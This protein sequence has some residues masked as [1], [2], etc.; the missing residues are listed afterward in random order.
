MT[1][2]N[3]RFYAELA[4][5]YHLLF[6]DWNAAI[7]RQAQVL[8][9]LIRSRVNDEPLRLLDCSCGIGTQSLGLAKLGYSVVGSDLCPAAID[10]AE[11]EAANRDLS[12]S[13]RISDMTSLAEIAET[14]FDVV[15]TL[16]NALPHLDA[17]ELILAIRAMASKIKPGGLLL[18]SIRDY[19]ALKPARPAIQAP[20]FTVKAE[21]RGSF[22]R[23]GTGRERTGMWSTF[24]SR[25]T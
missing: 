1:R 11:K 5:Y 10:R 12:I 21:S 22:I 7:G 15:A 8:N 19:D 3:V 9:P 25:S 4:A 20:A 14:D 18:A 2:T 13:F 16:D 23:C 17:N 6:D 24:T